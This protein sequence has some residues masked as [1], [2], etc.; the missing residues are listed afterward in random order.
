MYLALELPSRLP[1]LVFTVPDDVA[2]TLGQYPAS[3]GIETVLFPASNGKTDVCMRLNE[4]RFA[5]MFDRLVEDIVDQVSTAQ[6]AEAG[7]QK[8]VNRFG[9][10][11]QFLQ[12]LSPEGLSYTAQLGLYGELWFMCERLLPVLPASTVIQMW[13]GPLAANQDFQLA[14]LAIEVK[15]T[16]TKLPLR[17]RI[18]SE[19][20]LDA[21]GT[22]VLYLA[23]LTFD[24]RE[25][26][27][28]TL[29][30]LI[31]GI[32]DS[33]GNSGAAQ[34]FEDRLYLAGYADKHVPEYEDRS[35]TLRESH[36]C[37][38][39]DSFPRIVESDLRQGVGDVT[40]SIGLS[41]CL[42][43]EVSVQ[44][45]HGELARRADNV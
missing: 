36:I 35:Y 32:R 10:W 20:Q 1:M 7:I 34:L 18:Q 19:R 24:V 27:D 25:G 41:D 9:H 8:F 45:L 29:P 37:K 28:R 2:A 23:A 17:L 14:G 13:T 11:Q 4:P 5:E 30:Q 22:D 21:T 40:Y 16:S 43:Y 42:P 38:V 33:L 44:S 26:T 31:S 6:T 39:T 15:F 12:R 3:L